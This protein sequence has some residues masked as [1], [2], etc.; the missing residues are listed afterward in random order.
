MGAVPTAAPFT[1]SVAS[2]LLSTP[3]M[4][5]MCSKQYA[6]MTHS[7]GLHQFTWG[8]NIRARVLWGHMTRGGWYVTKRWNA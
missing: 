2:S 1:H 5:G 6:S 8:R 4:E 3:A 7:T